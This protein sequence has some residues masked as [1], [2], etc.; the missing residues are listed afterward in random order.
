MVQEQ[1]WFLL[2]PSDRGSEGQKQSERQQQAEWESFHQTQRYSERA[3]TAACNL[4]PQLPTE[5]GNYVPQ[6][7]CP[8]FVIGH[9]I[10]SI[11]NW[12]VKLYVLTRIML[13]HLRAISLWSLGVSSCCMRGCLYEKNT[14][15]KLATNFEQSSTHTARCMECL[16]ELYNERNTIGNKACQHILMSD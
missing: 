3:Q 9:P 11:L 5:G 6:C 16:T 8:H 15:L 1:D 10:A 12:K 7:S 13:G 4:P 14:L 2:H